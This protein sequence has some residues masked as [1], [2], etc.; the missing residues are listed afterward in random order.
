MFKDY[1]TNDR[2]NNNNMKTT[3]RYKQNQKIGALCLKKHGLKSDWNSEQKVRIEKQV[4]QYV[5]NINIF[6]TKQ[7]CKSYKEK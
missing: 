5:S 1:M 6:I 2:Y 4:L 7:T 3:T